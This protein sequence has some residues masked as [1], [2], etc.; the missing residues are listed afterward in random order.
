MGALGDDSMR[1][2]GGVGML[3]PCCAAILSQDCQC[4]K[5]H[6]QWQRQTEVAH[7]YLWQENA[8]HQALGRDRSPKLVLAQV[9]HYQ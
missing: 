2:T 6:C 1:V 9:L 5:W 7:V 3:A 8:W 4:V